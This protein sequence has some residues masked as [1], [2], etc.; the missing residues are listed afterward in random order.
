[1]VGPDFFR[2]KN[3]E[4]SGFCAVSSQWVFY[5]HLKPVYLQEKRQLVCSIDTFLSKNPTE[6]AG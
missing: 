4:K 2:F 6:A 3:V 5:G 1:M